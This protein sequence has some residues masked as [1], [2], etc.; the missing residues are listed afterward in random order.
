MLSVWL[1]AIRVKFLLASVIAVSLGLSLAW[2]SGHQIDILHALLT[3]AGVISLH[4]SVDLLND[5]WDFKRGI[6]TK[7]KRTKMSGGTGVLPEGLLTPKSVYIVGIAFLILG[8]IIGIYF[9]I[10]S[11]IN[12]TKTINM[13][14]Y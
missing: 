11:F 8:A 9:V 5:Y 7:T 10:I 1:R 6:D 12:C 13:I 3:F 4:A 2:H 14:S